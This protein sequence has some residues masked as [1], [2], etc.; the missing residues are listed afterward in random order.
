MFIFN[1]LF[2]LARTL[3]IFVGTLACCAFVL[4]KR[5]PFDWATRKIEKRNHKKNVCTCSYCHH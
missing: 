1:F 5:G 3:I 2:S 4:G